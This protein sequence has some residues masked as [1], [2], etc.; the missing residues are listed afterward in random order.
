MSLKTKP[1]DHRR[2]GIFNRFAGGKYWAS[3]VN[4]S[5][6]FYGH[7]QAAVVAGLPNRNGLPL[8]GIDI[9]AGPGIGAWLL[10]DSGINAT[11]V[12][13]EPSN[14]HF[15]GLKLAKLLKREKSPLR[16]VPV[17]GG[18]SELLKDLRNEKPVDFILMTRAAHEIAMSLRGKPQFNAAMAEL[19][20]S[21]RRNGVMIVADSEYNPKIYDHPRKYAHWMRLSQEWQM[22]YVGHSHIPSDYVRGKEMRRLAGRLGLKLVREY[23]GQYEAFFTYCN[24][25]DPSVTESTNVFY[26]QTYLRK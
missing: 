1:S 14:T 21:I 24:R 4:N 7:V 16:Y 10:A 17:H 25:R 13:Y 23:L 2:T 9:G 20:T 22:K 6:D 19:V 15:D 12:G 5:M 26:V 8:R 18:M 11:L 3:F